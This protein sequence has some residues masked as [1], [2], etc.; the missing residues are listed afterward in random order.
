MTS[1]ITADVPTAELPGGVSMPLVGFGTHP[2]RGEDAAAA[3]A[4]AIDVGFRS[5]DTATRYRNQDAVGDGIRRSGIARSELFLT[6]K[7]PPDCV[8][9]ERQTLEESLA[10]FGTDHLDL[11]LIHWPP[12]G[13]AGVGTWKRMLALRDE[14]MVRA[15]GVSNYSLKLLDELERETGEYPA[16]NQVQWSPVHYSERLAA[17]CA[18][19]AITLGAHSPFR[20]ARLDDPVLVEI[21]ARHRASTRQ[22][23]VKWNVQHGVAIVPKSAHRERMAEN[24]DIGFDLSPEE[25]TAIDDLSELE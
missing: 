18:H 7:L 1:A 6:S 4:T 2:L 19:R 14:G 13:S 16:V 11:W 9:L 5:V 22:V 10:L 24:L 15:I 17:G 3:V 20:S 12:G 21:A 8:G 25:I 23:I